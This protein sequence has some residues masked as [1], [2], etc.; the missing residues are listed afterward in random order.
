MLKSSIKVVGSFYNLLI[1]SSKNSTLPQ[2]I[3]YFSSKLI[4]SQKNSSYYIANIKKLS[5]R[6]YKD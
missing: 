3:L 2:D 5:I 4:L 6:K 1:L